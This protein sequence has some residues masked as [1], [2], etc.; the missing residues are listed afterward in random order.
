MKK[1]RKKKKTMERK[2]KKRKKKKTMKRK[3]KKRKKKKKQKADGAVRPR[4]PAAQEHELS[5]VMRGV[6]LLVGWLL[7]YCPSNMLVYLR[8][9]YA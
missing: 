8:D 6:C 1:K 2:K 7:A 9:G 5:A 4:C 3:K